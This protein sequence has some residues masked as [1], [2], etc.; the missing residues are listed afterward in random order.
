MT[1]LPSPRKCRCAVSTAAMAV[2][3]CCN[4]SPSRAA[5]ASPGTDALAAAD[6]AGW[7]G[8]AGA[9]CAHPEIINAAA[10]T[11]TNIPTR[12]QPIASWMPRQ[13]DPDQSLGDSC[14]QKKK[15]DSLPPGKVGFPFGP[16]FRSP[17]SGVSSDV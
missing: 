10:A 3:K 8:A 14:V 5:R 7:D 9:V 2:C 17:K 13:P 12:V 16:D 4:D 15:A 6:L 1:C 11:G